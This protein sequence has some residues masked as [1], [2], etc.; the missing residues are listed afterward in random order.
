[1]KVNHKSKS[2]RKR[3]SMVSRIRSGGMHAIVAL[4]TIS[5]FGLDA[6]TVTSDKVPVVSDAAGIKAPSAVRSTFKKWLE[7]GKAS[8]YGLQ[9]QGHKTAMGEK[10]DM[11]SLTC[12]HRTLPM[13]SWLRVTNLNNHKSVVVRVNDRGPMVDGRIVDLSY[14][15][16]QAV[17]MDGMAKVKLEAVA[18]SDPDIFLSLLRPASPWIEQH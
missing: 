15:A 18:G 12:A 14:A 16:A 11:N 4:T 13:G 9:F 7:F 3:Q 5:A 6:N 8:W 17:G 1:M 10:F 2:L